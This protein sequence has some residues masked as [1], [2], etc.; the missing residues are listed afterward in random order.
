MVSGGGSPPSSPDRG[1]PDS[2]RYSTVSEKAGRWH[3]R[4]GCRGSRER[5]W[6]A[7]ARLDMPVFKSTDQGVEVTYTLWRFDVDAFLKQYDEASMCPHIFA[8]LPGYPGKWART[9][10][11]G[12]DISV[13]DLLMHMERTFGNKQYYDAMIRTLYEV[14][15]RDDE[16]VEE[17]M[18]RI[19]EVVTVIRRAFQ[20]R[21][22]DR[23]RD[24][25]KDRFYHG[26]HPYLL[27]TL[28]FAM[29]ELPER[30][31]ACPTFDILYTLAKKLE[32]RQPVHAR[33]YTPSSEV[34]RD[35]HRH[36]VMPTGQVA[37]LEEEGS[38][39][40]DQVT[41]EDSGSKVEAAGGISV[42]LAQAMSRY[43]WEEQQCFMCGSPG[44]FTR[45]CPHSEAF[46]QWH[47]DQMGSKGVGENGTPV[48]GAMSPQP[49]VNVHVIGQ[50]RN[51]WLETGGPA[52]HWL[53]PEMLVEL[54]M[55]GRIFMALAD[56]GSQVNTIT[57]TLV[58]QYGFPI[59]PLEDLMDYPMDLMGLGGMHTSPLGFI[60]LCVQVWGI[61]GYDK[62]AVFLVVPNES[63][64]GQRVPLV[65]GTCTISRLINVTC[66]SEIDNLATP[67]ST[68]RLARL[69]SCRLGTVV[70]SPE[71]GE[72][73]EEGACGGSPEVNID[74]L[75]MVWESACLGPFQT[76]IIEG[77]VKPLLRSTSY[78][79]IT[80][81]RVE[82]R[83]CETK[84]LPLG[85]HVLHAYTCLKNG[86][87]RVSLVVRNV[88]DSKIFIKKGLPVARVVSA[89]LMSPTELSPE[90]EA[91]LG[92]ESRPEPLSVAVRQEKLLE[93]LNLD[94]L[95]CWSPENA[96]AARE[97]VL[98]YHDVFALESNELGCTS[99]V[100]H[101]IPIENE[102]PFKERFRRIPPP[103]LEEVHASLRDM[104]ESGAIHPS[105]SPWCNVVVLVQKKDS[106]LHFCID[107]RC[108]NACTKKDSY[109]LPWIQEALESMMGSAISHQW[110]SNQAFG[111]SRWPQDHSSTLLSLWGTSGFTSLCACPSSCAMHRRHFSVSCRTPWGS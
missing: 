43:Q 88:S 89:M 32:A 1:V 90:M 100:E 35:K 27:D 13:R 49:E 9:L 48:L 46:R 56:S 61:A 31:Q 60:I 41:G 106:T 105:Q 44:H 5:K 6:L 66:E 77:R 29:A 30:E 25:K 87:G 7:P 64:F 109:P 22:L 17:Y 55:E 99:A 95:A 15:Q 53:G 73:L 91:T 65:M 36:Y 11:E 19:H 111:R 39:L 50:V 68:A 67:W 75:V 102:E 86:S 84:P 80:P 10:D 54:T 18:L 26:L 58:Q 96:V 103:L 83:Q 108:L 28:S 92:E 59:L 70:P 34:Y 33:R 37:A 23:G 20:D 94:G 40:S 3:R 21:L 69:L 12:K 62:D 47:W 107:F 72:T 63:N 76:E 2:D 16:M 71:R 45:G 57:P 51:P 74:E 38:T 110:I 78:V 104:L 85:F 98:A 82:G 42:C 52:A 81:L 8:S 14:Q 79:M 97:L 4:R 101:E 93:K 24:L